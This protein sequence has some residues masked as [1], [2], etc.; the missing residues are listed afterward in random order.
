MVGRAGRPFGKIGKMAYNF[1][2]VA[3][4]SHPVR[5]YAFPAYGFGANYKVECVAID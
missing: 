5:I 3:K 2:N 1:K 4:I